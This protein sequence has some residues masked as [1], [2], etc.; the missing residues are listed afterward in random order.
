MSRAV[1]GTEGVQAAQVAMATE[2]NVVV[3]T[4]MGSDCDLFDVACGAKFRAMKA[5]EAAE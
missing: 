1:A 5:A 4:G 2:L 3:L